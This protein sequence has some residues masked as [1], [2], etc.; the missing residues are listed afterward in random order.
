MEPINK[1]FGQCPNCGS[2][3]R[4]CETMANEMKKKGFARKEWLYGY[5]YREGVV[6]DKTKEANIPIGASAPRFRIITDICIECGTIYAVDLQSDE[7]TK[8]IAPPKLFGP[9]DVPPISNDPRYS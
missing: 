8:S 7:A 3:D 4:F 9:G 6:I 2:K 1:Q 5:D